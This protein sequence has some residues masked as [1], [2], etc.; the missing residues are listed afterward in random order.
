MLVSK[1][2]NMAFTTSQI[3]AEECGIE[4]SKILRVI[5]EYKPIFD[6]INTVAFLKSTE[7]KSVFVYLTEEHVDYLM[8][9]FDRNEKTDEFMEKISDEFYGVN[10]ETVNIKTLPEIFEELVN[11]PVRDNVLPPKELPPNKEKGMMELHYRLHSEDKLLK[12]VNELAHVNLSKKNFFLF[13]GKIGIIEVINKNKRQLQPKPN[14]I[15]LFMLRD[16]NWMV[17]EYGFMLIVNTL[18]IKN[19]IVDIYGE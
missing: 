2:G 12:V 13:L 5:K 14:T 1:K 10:N 4:H 16:K 9:H 6:D 18:K 15:P 3:V 17:T 7:N 11:S 19:R 8:S